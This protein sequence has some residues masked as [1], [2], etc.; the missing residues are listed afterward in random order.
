MTLLASTVLMWLL[1]FRELCGPLPCT[2]IKHMNQ[3]L[4]IT[5]CAQFIAALCTWS[6]QA[7]GHFDDFVF[8]WFFP[9]FHRFLVG[10]ELLLVLSRFRN[11]RDAV[12]IG[13]CTRRLGTLYLVLQVLFY[14]ESH[15]FLRD[16]GA[17]I[18]SCTTPTL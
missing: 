14:V 9:P 12:L 1:D 5:S 6:S 10:F 17:H 13:R 4:L 7:A 2:T 16:G 18:P 11:Q 3:P 8:D 15:R